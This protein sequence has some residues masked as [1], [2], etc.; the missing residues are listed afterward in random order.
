MNWVYLVCDGV[1]SL[2]QGLEAI[3]YELIP[4]R[5]YIYM[6]VCML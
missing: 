5:V 6:C 3:Q 1:D 4:S 2:L